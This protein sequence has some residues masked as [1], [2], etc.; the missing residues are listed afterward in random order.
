MFTDALARAQLQ[1]GNLD[2]LRYGL[3]RDWCP[4]RL[5]ATPGSTFAYAN[6]NY[7]IVG[8]MLERRTGRTWDELVGRLALDFAHRR[9]RQPGSI[10]V[11]GAARPRAGR[12]QR[13][14]DAVRTE[15]R[16][17]AAH[18]PGRDRAHVGARLRALGGL[19]RRRGRRIRRPWC[20]RRRCG[21][22]TR[23]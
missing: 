9:P 22:C 4:Q 16:Q 3:L 10:K 20:R 2:E 11:D 19:E 23:R 13:Q 8:A 7:V 14:G 18:R 17:P 21:G 12:R 5:A 6:M 15:R 1:P